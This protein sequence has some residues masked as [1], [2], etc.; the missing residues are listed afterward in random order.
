[1][2]MHPRPH[3]VAW[4][5]LV[6]DAD[7]PWWRTHFPP[8]GW[9][10][11]CRVFALS[12]KE[13]QRL[14]KR[15]PDKAPAIER[16]TK[17]IGQRSPGGPREVQVPAG[18]DP[19]FDY[20]PGAARLKSAIPPERPGGEGSL[21]TGSTGGYG[22][23]NLTPGDD[24]LPSRPFPSEKLLP[25]DW[26]AGAYAERFLQEFGATIDTPVIYRDVIGEPL[27]IGAELFTDAAGS[28][29]D[30][31]YG[32]G[33]YM[34]LLSQTLIDPDEIWVRLEWND[35]L[36]KAIVRRRY[37][38]KFDVAGKRAA[39]LVAFEWGSDGWSGVTAF[40]SQGK[41]YL[42]GLRIGARLYQRAAQQK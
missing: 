30:D 39:A 32:R 29:K 24:S 26:I 36:Q 23:P 3:H 34:L 1:S 42:D 35:R 16:E 14:G 31:K 11:Q 5:G 10:C 17:L 8:N 25:T 27:V 22:L 2:V 7:D 15:G 41:A 37:V 20:A 19:G 6:L 13:L 21:K 9:G 28:L 38:A 33:K 40:P 4:D 12:A 18:I